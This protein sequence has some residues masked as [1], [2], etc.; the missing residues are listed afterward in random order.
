MTYGIICAIKPVVSWFK[1]SV[2]GD[3]KA[4]FNKHLENFVHAISPDEAGL[5]QNCLEGVKSS[6]DKFDGQLSESAKTEFLAYAEL[7]QDALE[8]FDF[9]ERAQERLSSQF[10]GAFSKEI[11]RRWAERLAD[12]YPEILAEPKDLIQLCAWM[13]VFFEGREFFAT[14]TRQEMQDSHF[15]HELIVSVTSS[16]R[17]I[18]ERR[19]F[20]RAESSLQAL[21]R[22]DLEQGIAPDE[23]AMMDKLAGALFAK[24]PVKEKVDTLNRALWAAYSVRRLYSSN[25][26]EVDRHFLAIWKGG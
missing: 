2:L 3:P 11:I 6:L 21:G 26:E 25:R 7:F 14:Y 1:A 16:Y 10:N 22:R 4:I 5:I 18:A 13:D 20:L 24:S 23:R 8:A 19:F 12:H 9:S 17:E 15:M